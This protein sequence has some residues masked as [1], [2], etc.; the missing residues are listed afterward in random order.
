MIS[1]YYVYTVLQ[2]INPAIAITALKMEFYLKEKTIKKIIVSRTPEL[3]HLIDEKTE[4]KWFKSNEDWNH[5]D[6]DY[7]PTKPIE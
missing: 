3:K 2:N 1:R 5:L 7:N 4:L 6:W